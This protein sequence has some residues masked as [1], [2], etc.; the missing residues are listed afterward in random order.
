MSRFPDKQRSRVIL[1]G[2]SDYEHPDQLQHLPAIRNNLT[3][4]ERALTDDETGVFSQN[5]CAVADS[6]DSRKTF[7]QR[8]ARAAG[9]AEDTLLVYYAGHGVLGRNGELY[10]TVRESVDDPSQ[11]EATAVPFSWVRSTIQDSPAAVRIVVLDCC[12]SGRAIG[13]MS[14]ASAALNQVTVEGTTILTSSSAN[15]VSQSVPGEK[16]TA[17]TGELIRLLTE[18]RDE[19]LRVGDMY[20][21]LHAA[22]TKRSLPTPKIVIS[23]TAGDLVLRKIVSQPPRLYD[24]RVRTYAEPIPPPI[25]HQITF[26]GTQMPVFSASQTGTVSAETYGGY[27]APPARPPEP[28]V[29]QVPGTARSALNDA[30]LIAAIVVLGALALVFV[31]TDAVGISQTTGAEK[32][33]VSEQR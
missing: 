8:L 33:A 14:T 2:T 10:L 11:I 19:Q 30:A 6:P 4:L 12:F 7:M 24:P 27:G 22:M 16:Y 23:Q 1:I 13:A 17:F 9:E 18:P 31:A 5:T 15:Q 28:Y 25:I 29:F 32:R 3:A 26:P 21:P 20:G